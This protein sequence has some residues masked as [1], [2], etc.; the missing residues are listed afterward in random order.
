MPYPGISVVVQERPHELRSPQKCRFK[1]GSPVAESETFVHCK[2]QSKEA[3][4]R[5]GKGGVA[6]K[7]PYL[8]VVGLEEDIEGDSHNSPTFT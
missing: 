4:N 3:K 1:L 5:D 2:L 7:Q 8:R 6:I